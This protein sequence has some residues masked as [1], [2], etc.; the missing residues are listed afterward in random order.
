[1]SEAAAVVELSIETN[2]SFLL[3][4]ESLRVEDP[5]MRRFG[6]WRIAKGGVPHPQ[7]C[8]TCGRVTKRWPTDVSRFVMDRQD[9]DMSWLPLCSRDYARDV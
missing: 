9:L 7:V 5:G 3:G 4:G 2:E 6:N 8:P 1:M